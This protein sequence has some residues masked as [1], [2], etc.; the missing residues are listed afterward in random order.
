MV[1]DMQMPDING[2]L[3]VKA[4][5]HLAGFTGPVP[6]VAITSA[7]NACDDQR[8]LAAGVTELL[9][10][11]FRKNNLLDRLERL[12]HAEGGR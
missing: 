5:R 2:V 1:I 11:P 4:L 6:I 3:I 7:P 10:K 9:V 12:V 8:C